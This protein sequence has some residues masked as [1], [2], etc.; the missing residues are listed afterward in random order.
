LLLGG[1]PPIIRQAIEVFCSAFYILV[2]IAINLLGYAIGVGG[3]SSILTK[4][5]SQEG[6]LTLIS[7]F[8][9]LLAGVCLMDFIKQ[10]RYLS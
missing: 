10:K 1:L 8:C 2:L 7:T 5:L 4:M 9:F 3:V 6:I